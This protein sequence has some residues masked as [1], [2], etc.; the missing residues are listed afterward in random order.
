MRETGTGGNSMFG[1]YLENVRRMRPLVHNITNYVTVNDVANALLAIGA[2]PIMADAPQEALEVAELCDGMNLN[3]GTF[4]S[5]RLQAM[6]LAGEH[7]N[8][9]NK[10]VVLDPVGI[11]SIA[12]RKQGAERLR[13]RVRFTAIRGNLSELRSLAMG[14]VSGG[15]VDAARKDML[16]EETQKETAAFL[17]DFSRFYSCI[18]VVTGSTDIVTDGTKTFLIRNGRPE[19]RQ[20]SGTGCMLSGIL[21]AFL[22]ANSGH[23][24][25]ASAAAA[26]AMGIAGEIAWERMAEG[27]GNAAYRSRIIDALYH[28]DGTVLDRRIKIQYNDRDRS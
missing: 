24:T 15:G 6:Q 27:D 7:A 17:A 18:S 4:S 3:M 28:L 5:E 22:A 16:T 1:E 13:C 23:Q 12:R 19:M 20:V 8:R 10:P 11:G 9:L 2:S 14:C 25:E 21:A 26:A